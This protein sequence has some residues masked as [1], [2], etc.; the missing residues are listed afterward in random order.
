MTLRKRKGR[1]AGLAVTNEETGET[2][3]AVEIER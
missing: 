3:S 1:A 2:I